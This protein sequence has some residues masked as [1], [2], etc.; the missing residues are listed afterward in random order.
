MFKVFII[1]V[2]QL[3]DEKKYKKPTHMAEKEKNVSDNNS[4]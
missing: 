4:C 3:V 2:S 1:F